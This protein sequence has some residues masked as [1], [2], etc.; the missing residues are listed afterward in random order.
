MNATVLANHMFNPFSFT[1]TFEDMHR[2]CIKLCA[3]DVIRFAT[4][5][6]T[7][8]VG[9]VPLKLVNN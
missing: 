4:V 7:T 2:I 9:T 6:E 8:A 3:F 1:K 5:S